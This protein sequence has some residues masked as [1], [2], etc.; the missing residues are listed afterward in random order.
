MD[1]RASSGVRTRPL[2]LSSTLAG[3]SAGSDGLLGDDCMGC[4]WYRAKSSWK[5]HHCDI[6][7][8]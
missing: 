8:S 1:F 7:Q 3:E 6:H 4:W 2:H 5:F